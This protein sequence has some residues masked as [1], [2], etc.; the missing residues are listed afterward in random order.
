MKKK[1]DEE[2]RM[3]ESVDSISKLYEESDA[4]KRKVDELKK[5]K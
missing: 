5:K 4:I 2:I 1:E 3:A